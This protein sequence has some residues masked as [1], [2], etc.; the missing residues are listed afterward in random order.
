MAKSFDLIVIGTG[1][2]AT[3]V[4]SRCQNAGWQVAIVDNLPYG[5][6][7]QLR[8]CDPKK[9]LVGAAETMD[10]VRRLKGKGIEAGS[11]RI[12]WP[13][14]MQFK[15]SFVDPVPE[16]N[17]KWLG[18]LGIETLHGQ[19]RFISPTT[20]AV[21]GE[22]LQAKHVHIATGA[23]PADLGIQG[24]EHMTTS[25]DFLDLQSLPPR[26]V[27]VGGGFI[28][29]EFAHVSARAGAEVT[30]L[31]RG[32]KPLKG[33]DPDLVAMLV[34][35]SRSLGIEIQLAAEVGEI[36]ES[37]NGYEVV[38][39]TPQGEK[40]YEGDLVVHGAGR[41]P[42]IGH[43]GLDAA[44]VAY[45][46]R[47]VE[48]NE[49]LQSVSNPA[50]YAAGDCADTVGL[51]LT[52]V[53]AYEGGIAAKN[54]LEGNCQPVSHPPMPST[55]FTIPPLA[56][57]G[58]QEAEAK[59]QGLR[60]DTHFGKTDSWYS[61]RRIGEDCSGYKVLVEEESGKILGAQ[62]LGSNA[63]ELINLFTMAINGSISAESIKDIIFAYPTYAS[64]MGYMV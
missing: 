61:L 44:G 38:A 46:S 32:D 11:A 14:L 51:P 10:W 27:F 58:L 4:A 5:G 16:G 54:L 7:C 50:V 26:I 17:E 30:I 29:F 28:S 40:R 24:Q 45:G 57:V 8:G 21:E 12:D 34:E 20:V 1:A 41:T 36:K 33:F 62:I 64:D 15:Q 2:G 25:T 43:L 23:V 19:A 3:G 53:G 63:E 60:F 31:H 39:A 22:P 9:V 48:V 47:G 42:N 52:P 13:A 59:S 35:K 49:Y 55:V 18:G 56:A 6:T 37:G